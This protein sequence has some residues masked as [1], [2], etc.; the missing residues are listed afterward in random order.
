MSGRVFGKEDRL[1]AKIN[2]EVNQGWEFVT[3]GQGADQWGFALLKRE[4]K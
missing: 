4:K 1:D 3:A 2:D